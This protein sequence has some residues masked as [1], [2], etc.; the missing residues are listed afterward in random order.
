[1]F[2]VVALVTAFG[3]AIEIDQ[4][5][6]TDVRIRPADP[7]APAPDVEVAEGPL[8]LRIVDAGGVGIPADPSDW[9]DD[10]SHNPRTFHD[11]LLDRA[12]WIDR[13]QWERVEAEW[14]D[15]VDRMRA[16]GNNGI[17]V[18][19]FLE[20][21][22]FDAVGG[23][24]EV[25]P[26]G[27]AARD[28]AETLARHFGELITTTQQR[29]M[30]VYLKTDMLALSEPLER[31]LRTRFGGL[32]TDEPELW[33]VYRAGFEEALDDLGVDG[34]IVRIGEA[35]PLYNSARWPVWSE[36]HVRDG[37]E[38]RAMLRGLLPSFEA[39]DRE[40]ILRSWSVGVGALGE[41]HTDPAVY[42]AVLG[43]IESEHLVVSTKLVGGDYYSYFPL[44]RTLFDGS[45]RRLVELQSRR[46]Y[47]GFGA[48]PNHLG[49]EHQRA[50][51][52]FL[53]ANP[54]IEGIYQWTQE[55]GPLR[56]GPRSLY[57]FEGFWLWIDANVA[58]TS[59][60]AVDPDLDV[61]TVTREW[62]RTHF[63]HDPLVVDTL[64]GL[65]LG[66]HDTVRSGLYVRPY[67]EKAVWFA[68]IE[69]PP[70]MWIFE[71]D[72]VGGWNS[73]LSTV[74][75]QSRDRFDEAVTEGRAALD[76]VRE[77]R[78]AVEA[79]RARSVP[80]PGLL[81]RA[82][83]SLRYQESLFAALAHYREAFLQY[84]RWL[85]D[86]D[87]D[88]QAAWL[89]A[90]ESFES[91]RARHEARWGGN[92]DFPA[93]DFA[94]AERGLAIAERNSAVT[95]FARLLL[96]LLVTLLIAGTHRVQRHTGPWPGRG[97]ARLLFLGAFAPYRIGE[98]LAERGPPYRAVTLTVLAY[99]GASVLAFS[100]FSTPLLSLGTVGAIVVFA[101]VLRTGW[102]GPRPRGRRDRYVPAA[103]AP[104]LLSA[105]IVLV[106][107]SWTGPLGFWLG[108]WT[109]G[110]VRGL[111]LTAWIASLLWAVHGLAV[112]GRR[113]G[114]VRAPAALG[115]LMVAGGVT[116]AILAAVWPHT[117]S[118]LG[119]LD[120]GLVVLPM[121]ASMLAG[122][123]E[124]LGVG[125]VWA[126]AAWWTAVAALVIV[127]GIFA[128]GLREPRRRT[129]D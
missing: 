2:L 50:L 35:G 92:L 66:S 56:A 26:A 60:L 44:N 80:D 20:L 28:R 15:H 64:V 86:R 119:V 46:E 124:Y 129:T 14:F 75:A 58:V 22:T 84:Y 59:A 4:A 87:R 45:H 118:V 102:N 10:Y 112:S 61:Q 81:D 8:P 67:A 5:V 105:G 82:I 104:L 107:V 120:H 71:W 18:P 12:P 78:R 116:A 38:V 121:G 7:P 109:E 68:G 24:S 40:L 13:E 55:G 79:L 77:Q 27:S 106:A 62:V 34:V 117:A 39:R 69:L 57:A 63:G 47:E 32:P 97:V 1:M 6:R 11:L 114:S 23:G 70:M 54:R 48:F 9:G 126:G 31:Y 16:Y 73:V 98:L 122:V 101:L 37:R 19:L 95:W 94:A 53:A 99:C 72:H 91:A 96:I 33:S 74:Y 41:L 52:T 25:I 30:R 83:D 85:D 127:G 88:S 115:G 49:Q 113:L 90:R 17:V 3:L 103:F 21:L 93:Y 51:R 128:R 76:A 65:L 29:G 110:W 123:T 100:A 42:D 89:R 108:F 111:F 125:E 43:P 36:M